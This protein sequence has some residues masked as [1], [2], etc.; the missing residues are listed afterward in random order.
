M[1][2]AELE[3]NS[4]NLA[5]DFANTVEDRLNE[6][7]EDLLRTPADLAE[8]G[9]MAGLLEEAQE[10]IR[11]GVEL[12]KALELR[13]HLTA[14]LDQKLD[15]HAFSPRDLAALAVIEADADLA[16]ILEQGEDGLLIRRWDPGSLAT[17][18]HMVASVAVKLLS[19]P[20]ADRIGRCAGA[21]CGWFF[22][23]ATKRGN[24][25][26]CSMRDCGQIAKS[27]NRRARR[28]G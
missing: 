7:P 26:W 9:A 15:G 14:L 28:S 23:D 19:S 3:L 5:L 1:D 25:R 21:G 24:R 6:R 4:G 20:A 2:V 18:R 13:E 22:L 11:G 27:E 12:G 8:W 16:G 10:P 17:V